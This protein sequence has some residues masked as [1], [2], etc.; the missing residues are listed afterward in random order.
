MLWRIMKTS[1]SV[2]I[3]DKASQSLNIDVSIAAH[4]DWL[5]RLETYTAG[6]GCTRQTLPATVNAT[7]ASGFT[8]MEKN[9]WVSTL[10]FRI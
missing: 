10:H 4:E 9:T 3:L 8:P 1:S 2:E 5:T 6:H 7:W